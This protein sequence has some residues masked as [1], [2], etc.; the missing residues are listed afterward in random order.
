MASPNDIY[1]QWTS[2][3]EPD[4]V[5]QLQI[6]KE[7]CAEYDI[8]LVKTLFERRY[9]HRYIIPLNKIDLKVAD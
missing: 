2:C 4:L 8:S 1:K 6:L 3:P 5:K 9:K 7:L